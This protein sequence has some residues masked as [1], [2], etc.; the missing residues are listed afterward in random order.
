MEFPFKGKELPFKGNEFPL[1]VMQFPFEGSC[2]VEVCL[3]ERNEQNHNYH[4]LSK[5]HCLM[6]N[7]N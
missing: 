7:I 2:D 3:V 4:T 5:F 6:T 1:K